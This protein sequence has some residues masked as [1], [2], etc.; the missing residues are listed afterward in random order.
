M[1][2][3]V[4]NK[5]GIHS[6][7][8]HKEHNPTFDKPPTHTHT[9]THASVRTSLLYS[10]ENAFHSEIHIKRDHQSTR[11]VLQINICFTRGVAKIYTRLDAFRNPRLCTGAPPSSRCLLNNSCTAKLECTSEACA[12]VLV[13]LLG[14]LGFE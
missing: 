9:H 1:P 12:Q 11:A 5:N 7:L 4:I 10:V 13:C 6:G 3:Q 2:C 14:K 8:Y